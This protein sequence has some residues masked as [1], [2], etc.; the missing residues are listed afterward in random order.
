MANRLH[1][2]LRFRNMPAC[3]AEQCRASAAAHLVFCASCQ[4]LMR[5]NRA[6][7]IV[8][9]ASN[10]GK[11]NPYAAVQLFTFTRP[12]ASSHTVFCHGCAA[13]ALVGKYA[14]IPPV[15][16]CFPFLNPNH[17]GILRGYV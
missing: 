9:S 1:K 15:S 16:A 11:R 12:A 7:S 4:A 2:T 8:P 6:Q 10:W 3:E 13:V 5:T 17:I 14:T